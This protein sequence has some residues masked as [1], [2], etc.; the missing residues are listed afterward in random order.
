[1][2]E[3]RPSDVDRWL[4]RETPQVRKVLESASRYFDANDH[5]TV[6]TL[7]AVYGRENSFGI[8]LGKRGSTDAAGHFQFKPETARRYGLNVSKQNDQ[9]FDIDRASSAAARYL[10]DLNTWFGKRTTLSEGLHTIP[11]K[12]VSERKKFVLG[13]FNAGEGRIAVVQRLAEKAGR[14]PQLWDDVARYLPKETQQYVAKVS[15]YEAEFALKSSANKNLKKKEARKGK[16]L[17]TVGH[18]RMIDD[19]PVFIC[20]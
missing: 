2:P 20:A 17:C 3:K 13:A 16:Y 18:W 4:E 9:R 15:L 11:V 6:N 5:L 10:K 8:L 1:M 7:E 19:R 12:N 14:N